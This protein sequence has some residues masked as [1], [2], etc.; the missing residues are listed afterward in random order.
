MLVNIYFREKELRSAA[1]GYKSSVVQTYEDVHYTSY[2]ANW[3][4]IILNNGITY[5][6]PSDL[7]EKI[8]EHRSK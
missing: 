2:C 8:V 3:Y 5:R 7:V 6:Y 4:S 1:S